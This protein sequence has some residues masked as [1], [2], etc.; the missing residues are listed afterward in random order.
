MQNTTSQTWHMGEW[1]FWGWL[2]TA[3]KGLGILIGFVA[4][5]DGLSADEFIFGDH[6][7]LAAV[8]LL[9]LLTVGMIAPLVLRYTQKEVVSMA[10]AI[11]NF[12]GHG[13]LLFGLLRQPDQERYVVLFGAAFVI[14]ELVKQRF[15]TITGYAEMGQTTQQMLNYSRIVAAVYL[16]LII[17]VMI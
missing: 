5:F 3:V 14:G 8:I 12:L 15:L 6:P 11:L 13:A 10:Y 16:V 1:G 17:L 7:H 2:E 4:F 9:A